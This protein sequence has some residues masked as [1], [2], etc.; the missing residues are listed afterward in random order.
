MNVHEIMSRFTIGDGEDVLIDLDKSH[1]SWIVDKKSGKELLDL[2]SQ[3]ASQA[4]GWNHP[5]LVENEPKL[6]RLA[7][8]KI[9]NPDFYTEE[10]AEFT[11]EFASNAKDFSYFFFVEGGS[12]G[13]ENALKCAF[14]YKARKLNLTQEDVNNLDVIHLGN[15]FHG[16]GGFS[17]STLGGISNKTIL[18]PKLKW[19]RVISPAITFP[20]NHEEVSHLEDQSIKEIGHAIKNRYVAAIL[21]EPMQSEGGDRHFRKE[22]LEKLRE[23]A[24]QNDIL[25][26]FDEVQTGVGISGKYWTYENFGAI[27]DLMCFGKKTQVCGFCSTK[28]VDEVP[29][30][31]FKVSSRINS[32]FGGNFLDMVRFSI[33][34]KVIKEENLVQNAK[35]VG[36][37]FLNKMY[38]VDKVKN[39]R[40]LGLMIA[41]DLPDTE[42]RNKVLD[43]IKNHASILAC[44]DKSIRIR[45][46]LTFKK[47]E[48][49]TAVEIISKSVSK[50]I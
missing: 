4:L 45:P 30:N 13:V 36:E 12:A 15:A 10:L 2:S 50:I 31:V 44:G 3:F 34:S 42:T 24:T 37:Y 21:L 40:G 32:T 39:V 18:F 6:G 47:E 8:F 38:S 43:A 46:H 1:G 35:E 49:D 17:L 28:K 29:E 11:E 5:R 20:V 14:D 23:I 33:I 27:P 16:R 19:T 48:A 9:A 41:F 26:I 22:Y 25:L 7:K